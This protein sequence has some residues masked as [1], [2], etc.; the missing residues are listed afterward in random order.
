[1]D[2]PIPRPTAN[3]SIENV[4]FPSFAQSQIHFETLHRPSPVP[5]NSPLRPQ[6][7]PVLFRPSASVSFRMM[8]RCGARWRFNALMTIILRHSAASTIAVAAFMLKPTA[9]RSLVRF[10]INDFNFKNDNRTKRL[11]GNHSSH[12]TDAATRYR[13]SDYSSNFN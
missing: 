9:A 5:S 11:A 7:P 12:R 6:Q 3:Q 10:I 8:H 1:M 4:D 2:L 13:T